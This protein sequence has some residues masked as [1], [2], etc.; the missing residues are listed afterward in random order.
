MS[1]DRVPVRIAAFWGLGAFATT[2]MLNGVSIGLLFFL[3]TFVKIDP[4]VAGALLFAS[5]LFDACIDPGIGQLSDRTV[6][7]LGRRRPWLL[8]GSFFC[9]LSFAWLFNVPD[10]GSLAPA[11]WFV[12]LGLLVYTIAYA[13]FT[14]P[15]LAM[16]GDLTDDYQER[17]HL[18]SWRTVFMTI[19]NLIGAAGPPALVEGLGG[20]REAYGQMGWILGAVIGGAMLLTVLGT[21]G[22]R[23]RAPDRTYVPMLTQVRLLGENRPLLVLMGTKISMYIGIAAFQAVLLFFFSSILKRSAGDVAAFFGVMTVATIVCTPLHLALA[24]RVEKR[25]AYLWCL[26][27]YGLGMLSW[28]MATPAEPAVWFMARAVWLG[29]F[30]AGLMLFGYSMLIDTYAWDHL[31]TGQRREGFLASA[32]SFVEKVSLAIGPFIV[33]ALLSMLGFDKTLAP[34]ADQSA[35]AQ[36]AILLGFIWIPLITQLLAMLLLRH[37]HLG[38]HDLESRHGMDK[39]GEGIPEASPG[40]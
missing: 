32:I 1:T 17:S 40:G 25:S 39:M 2:T 15:Y 5:K 6:S 7:R 8:A 30:N 9:G 36:Q 4:W 33:G 28:T 27:A 26:G 12:G 10:A 35:S 23:Q 29:A 18:M 13:T 21:A 31:Q 11:Y 37:Y 20:G 34:S 38:R 24:R 22:G 19:G 14:V 3:V 16:P